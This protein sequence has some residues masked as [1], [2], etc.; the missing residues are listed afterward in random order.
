MKVIFSEIT[1]KEC[2]EQR[3]LPLGNEKLAK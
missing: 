2:I 3:C 1:D